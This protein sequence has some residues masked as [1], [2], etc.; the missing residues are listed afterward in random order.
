MTVTCTAS[1]SI[2]TTAGASTFKI[3]VTG[4]APAATGCDAATTTATAIITCQALPDATASV[5]GPATETICASEASYAA[6]FTATLANQGAGSAITSSVV[7]AG[8]HITCAQSG[9]G[10]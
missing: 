8:D 5:T 10:V 9:S 1:S 7:A 6:S 2:C 3:K 4:T